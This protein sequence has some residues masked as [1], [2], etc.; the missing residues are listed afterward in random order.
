M[1]T[2]GGGERAAAWENTNPLLAFDNYDGIKTGTTNT[3]G[4][5]L[6]ASGQHQGRRL[7]LALLGSAGEKAR[8]VDARNL[9]RWVWSR[10]AV[11]PTR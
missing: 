6:V 3:A 8:E 11:N 4:H 7:F 5:C 9:F 1:R 10:P 2:A